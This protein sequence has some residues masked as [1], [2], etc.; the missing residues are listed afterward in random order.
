MARAVELDIWKSVGIGLLVQI[1]VIPAVVL[2]AV[3]ILGIPLIPLGIL[4][5][6]AACIMG[7]AGFALL[8]VRRAHQGAHREAPAVVAAVMLGFL[9]LNVMLLLGH[10]I[11]ILGSPFNILGWVLIIVNFIVFWFATTVG[12]GAVWTTRLGSRDE[13]AK[14]PAPATPPAIV[15]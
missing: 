12:L 14:A 3:S 7:F 5:L 13:T 2:M 11:N 4:L 6:A 1:S 10:L 8:I 9:M 15:Q